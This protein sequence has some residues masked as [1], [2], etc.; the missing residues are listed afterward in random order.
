MVAAQTSAKAV[1]HIEQIRIGGI[2]QQLTE[3][4]TNA[5]LPILLYL[6]GGPGAATSAHQE[7]ITKDLEKHFIVVHWDQ[8]GSKNSKNDTTAI[9]L[10]V[11]KKDTEGVLHYLLNK[12]QRD[13]LYILG[14]S[15]GTVLGFHLSATY[16][17]K[18][19]A[20][21]AVNPIIDNLKSQQLLQQKLITHY[22]QQKNEQAL[23]KLASV[24]IPYQT[25]TDLCTQYKWQADFEGNPIPDEHYKG[26]C[27]YFENWG[28][29]YMPLYKELYAHPIKTKVTHLDCPLIIMAGE[30]DNTANYMLT[31]AYFDSIAVSEK[32][33][34][35]F[36][37]TG[38]NIPQTQAAKMQQIVIAYTDSIKTLTHQHTNTNTQT[39]TS[40]ISIYLENQQTGNIHTAISTTE[41]AATYT[42]QTPFKIASSTK[43][44]VATIILQ[45][46][47]EHKLT[48]TDSLATYMAT[49]S[50]ML[51]EGK[52]L[53]HTITLKQLLSHKSGLA[54]IFT[55][56]L[57][58]FLT[59]VVTNTTKQYSPEAI[60]KLYYTYGLH[61][62]PH[63]TPGTGFYYSD[64]NYV[65][66][67]MLI[68]QIEQKPLAECIRTRI[69]SPLHMQ[70][71]YLQHYEP[72]TT[73]L[74]LLDQYI[75]TYNFKDINTSFDWAG[76]GLVSTHHD[77]AIFIK[78]LFN[79]KLISQQSLQKMMATQKTGENNSEYGLGMYK[80]IYNQHTFYGHYGFYGSYIAYAPDTQTVVSYNVNQ[81]ETPFN[82]FVLL[83][84]LICI[85][86]NHSFHKKTDN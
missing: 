86:E 8:R 32:L 56:K 12:Y 4:G 39:R 28:K 24:H 52:N 66:L 75:G 74:P 20:F 54:D 48:L 43:L 44:F 25:V 21:F 61:K 79:G 16:P 64:I 78:A 84:Q 85:F 38:H 42:T 58:P 46:A 47:E 1:D 36:Q 22:K 62:Q 6:H 29:L 51:L 31:K 30:T 49:D 65:L 26:L 13:K 73:T 5:D 37:K 17:E 15:W 50:L 77:L 2:S 7:H 18:I 80:T 57:N 27:A 60:L 71:T 59:S 69:L 72:A 10:K 3:K 14:N 82:K 40:A 19:H 63:F 9:S 23:T 34:Y 53:G 35:P 55:D 41:A 76:G 81:A 11:M 68:E 45:L 70:N 33:W 67:G 83:N